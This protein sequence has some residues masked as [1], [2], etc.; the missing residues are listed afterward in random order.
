MHE[1]ADFIVGPFFS[2]RKPTSDRNETGFVPRLAPM[3]LRFHPNLAIPIRSLPL[4]CEPAVPRG[5]NERNADMLPSNAGIMIS[6]AWMV[7][8]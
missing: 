8:A 3:K 1:R 5:G 2:C 7:F 4:S 6:F